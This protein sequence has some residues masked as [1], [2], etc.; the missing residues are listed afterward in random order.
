V[1]RSTRKTTRWNSRRWKSTKLTRTR[2]FVAALAALVAAFAL[3]LVP[4]PYELLAPGNAVA[5]SEHV[6][7]EGR[8]PP[9]RQFFLT[10]VD[11][12]RASVLLLAW[13]FW[14][15]VQLVA[16][17]KLVPRG[18]APRDYDRMMAGAMTESQTIA[19]IVA[20]RAAGY[21]VPMPPQHTYIAAFSP[22]SHARG[23]LREGDDLVRVAGVAIH[24]PSDVAGA[25]RGLR[26]GR[27]VAIAFVRDGDPKVARV[28]TIGIGGSPLLGVAI[29]TRTEVPNLP[30]PVRYSLGN[31]AGS[32]GGLMLALEIYAALRDTAPG[33]AV[34]GTGTLAADGSVGPIEGVAQKIVA[35]R[36]AGCRIFLVPRDD[37]SAAA[38]TTDIRTIPVSNFNEAVRAL[39]L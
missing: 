10:D 13:R 30:V 6:R 5:L 28:A 15:G 1:R 7:V 34:A 9:R 18:L 35:A 38:A 14:P 33:A 12:T 19:A 23:V 27:T 24:R 20:E 25:L 21:A 26:P 36:R 11:V 31:I 16:D 37:A 17:D 4:A 3:S 32:S 8:P 2:L 22:E 39:N 29:A